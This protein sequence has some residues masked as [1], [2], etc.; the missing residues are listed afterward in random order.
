MDALLL[1]LIIFSAQL[2]VI[3]EVLHRADASIGDLGIVQSL[4]DLVR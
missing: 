4:S 1:V 3:D 2:L